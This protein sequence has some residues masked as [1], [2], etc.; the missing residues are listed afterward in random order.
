M[1]VY[2]FKPRV[3]AN[4]SAKQVAGQPSLC[5]EEKHLKQK[6]CKKV[7]E[8]PCGMRA[9]ANNRTWQLWPSG[10]GYRVKDTR[11]GS[12]NLLL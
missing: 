9:P 2:T 6:D 7:F 12:W 11:K 8:E 5:N 1:V 4:Q 3:K 10:S